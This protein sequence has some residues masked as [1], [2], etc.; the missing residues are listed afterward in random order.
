MRQPLS[1]LRRPSRG[2]VL[3]GP[4]FGSLR[5][6]FNR[7]LRASTSSGPESSDQDYDSLK[8]ARQALGRKQKFLDAANR[9]LDELLEKEPKPSPSEI[10]E[11]ERDVA[12]A[13]RDV[14]KAALE[15]FLKNNPRPLARD[16]AATKDFDAK[17][18]QLQLNV[19]QAEW[20]LAKA[21]LSFAQASNAPGIELKQKRKAEEVCIAVVERLLTAPGPGQCAFL[22]LFTS[23]QQ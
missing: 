16:V 5:V 9:A 2:G 6:S 19:A 3:V 11:A 14:A 20:N 12:K 21:D 8:A 18:G 10:A 7:V 15:A 1:L 13:K 4:S 23:L 17:E 22:Y